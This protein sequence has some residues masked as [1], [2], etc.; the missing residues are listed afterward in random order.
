M[1]RRDYTPFAVCEQ[2]GL[3]ALPPQHVIEGKCFPIY[4]VEGQDIISIHHPATR[5]RLIALEQTWLR[6][7][8]SISL[9]TKFRNGCAERQY[10]PKCFEASDDYLMYETAVEFLGG[11]LMGKTESRIH[12]TAVEQTCSLCF[13][14]GGVAVRD[15]YGFGV[16]VFAVNQYAQDIHAKIAPFTSELMCDDELFGI[17]EAAGRRGGEGAAGEEGG[18]TVIHYWSS[19]RRSWGSRRC[20]R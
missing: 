16:L 3:T 9:E 8:G 10:K 20:C 15:E 1:D 14:Y 17:E 4:F 19:Q 7:Q 12:Q 6:D 5:V 2:T 13:P 18:D 11:Q